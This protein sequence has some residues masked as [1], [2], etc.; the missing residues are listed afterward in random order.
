GRLADAESLAREQLTESEASGN[1]WV[2]GILNVLLG[3]VTLWSG[4]PASAV[5]HAREGVARFREIGDAWG[6]TQ[7][8]VVLVRSLAAAGRIDDAFAALDDEATDPDAVSTYRMAAGV[9]DLVRAQLLVHV[10]DPDALAAALHVGATDPGQLDV[11]LRMM[12]GM[13]QLEAGRVVEAIAEL[14]RAKDAVAEADAGPGAAVRT[15]RA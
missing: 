15:A 5:V 3:S 4:R 11:E 14:D 1:R 10:G 9:R 6:E 7:A 8:L 12:L 13:A 2:A